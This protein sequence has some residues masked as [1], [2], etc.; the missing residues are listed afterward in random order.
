MS[1][2]RPFISHIDRVK[3][4][5]I[6]GSVIIDSTVEINS[7]FEAKTASFPYFSASDALTVDAGIADSSTA[8]PFTSGSTPMSVSTANTTA[9]IAKSLRNE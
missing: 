8:I 7:I 2:R 5:A 4:A 9:G 1:L 6:A 3:T